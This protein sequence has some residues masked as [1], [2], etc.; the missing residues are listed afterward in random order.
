MSE[1]DFSFHGRAVS[2]RLLSNCISYG[3]RPD[4]EDEVEQHLTLSEDGSV[5]LTCFLYGDGIEYLPVHQRIPVIE[6]ARAQNLL[7]AV[8]EYFRAP[9]DDLDATDLGIWNLTLKNEDGKQFY[10]S[11]SLGP[12]TP[13]LEELSALLRQGLN[14]PSLLAF[15]GCAE[16]ERIEA[17]TLDFRKRTRRAGQQGT[18]IHT[19]QITL[20]RCSSS[21]RVVCFSENGVRDVRELTNLPEIALLLDELDAGALCTFQP[22]E[23]PAYLPEQQAITLTLFPLHGSPQ[24][25]QFPLHGESLPAEVPQLLGRIRALLQEQPLPDILL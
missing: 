2:A 11:G 12:I 24:T 22:P 4:R 15:D 7:D 19:E 5:S 6:P 14:M 3:P 20:E 21:L 25:L 16:A 10:Y 23:A 17:L 8:A 13:V 18:L 9:A 1:P